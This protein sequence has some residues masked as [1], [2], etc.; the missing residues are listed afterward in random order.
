MSRIC[1][2]ITGKQIHEKVLRRHPK[3]GDKWTHPLVKKILSSPFFL[4]Q[5]RRGLG[6]AKREWECHLLI[7]ELTLC[8]GRFQ[9]Y[10]RLLA[11][12][13]ES[14]ILFSSCLSNNARFRRTYLMS[15]V[16]HCCHCVGDRCDVHSTQLL[17][18]VGTFVHSLKGQKNQPW[19][20]KKCRYFPGW[21][22]HFVRK[23]SHCTISSLKNFFFFMWMIRRKKMHPAFHGLYSLFV[24]KCLKG[25]LYLKHH[26][27]LFLYV[28]WIVY[29]F[30]INIWSHLV[31]KWQKMCSPQKEAI[32]KLFYWPLMVGCSMD[33]KPVLIRFVV[34]HKN[35]QRTLWWFPFYQE[36]LVP[37]K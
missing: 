33:S 25:I 21:Q 35:S 28:Y 8:H 20:E 13:C 2:R 4:R 24:E 16:N 5:R 34:E 36:I 30:L 14:W 11:W 31:Y 23:Y 26:I 22:L 37:L 6:I 3:E 19:S 12:Q 17:W 27:T 9:T 1:K 7:E 32:A 15:F 10:F 29:R 18:L